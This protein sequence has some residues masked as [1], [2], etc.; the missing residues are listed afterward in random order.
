[1]FIPV[2]TDLG[3]VS[4]ECQTLMTGTLI[5]ECHV[6][7]DE[8]WY[9]PGVEIEVARHD[10][11]VLRTTATEDLDVNVTIRGQEFTWHI[12]ENSPLYYVT[13]FGQKNIKGEVLDALHYED[14]E[15]VP[16]VEGDPLTGEEVVIMNDFNH[17][18]VMVANI[19]TGAFKRLPVSENTTLVGSCILP[20]PFVTTMTEVSVVVVERVANSTVEV[21]YYDSELLEKSRV[22]V[23][24]GYLTYGSVS[25]HPLDAT[26]ILLM[27][28]HN[29]YLLRLVVSAD[30]S[31]AGG[32]YELGSGTIS[33]VGGVYSNNTLIEYSSPYHSR[34]SE[35]LDNTG[36]SFTFH[37]GQPSITP[38]FDGDAS[39]DQYIF[40]IDQSTS[41]LYRSLNSAS[42]SQPPFVLLKAV[43]SSVVVTSEQT[44]RIVVSYFD[45]P[46]ADVFNEELEKIGEL[47]LGRSAYATELNGKIVSTILYSD[48]PQISL[49]LDSEARVH[50]TEVQQ[51]INQPIVVTYN[52]SAPR[53]I[54]VRLLNDI[55]EVTV[56][57]VP[58]TGGLLPTSATVRFTVPAH[59][60]YWEHR[61]VGFTGSM[62]YV[63]NVRTEPQLFPTG[64]RPETVYD[65]S[66]RT[67]YTRT[68]IIEGLTEGFEAEL[69]SHSDQLDISVNGNEF[70]KTQTVKWRDEVTLNWEL[71]RFSDHNGRSENRVSSY[72]D[73]NA[74]LWDIIV[75]E[76]EGAAFIH[77]SSH[78]KSKLF[79]QAASESS[80]MAPVM[81]SQRTGQTSTDITTVHE[82]D[83]GV[84]LVQLHVGDQERNTQTPTQIAELTNHTAP[85]F[86][87]LEVEYGTMMMGTSFGLRVFHQLNHEV[88]T[89]VDY[90]EGTFTSELKTAITR[91]EVPYVYEPKTA[92]T[93]LEVP[94][95]YALEPAFTMLE[96]PYGYEPE[97]TTTRF[98]VSYVY[99]LK[100]AITP[101]E[102]P[103]VYE[104]ESAFTLREVEVGTSILPAL[105]PDKF[106]DIDVIVETTLGGRITVVTPDFYPRTGN[107]P[108]EVEYNSASS[109]QNTI[110]QY[111]LEAE[112]LGAFSLHMELV[113]VYI[114]TAAQFKL[115]VFDAP[116][117]TYMSYIEESLARS[118]LRQ[119]FAIKEY[120]DVQRMY[121]TWGVN[122]FQYQ[123]TDT[124]FRT[125]EFDAP[126]LYP[127]TAFFQILEFERETSAAQRSSEFEF[128]QET[129]AGHRSFEF[130]SER[131]TSAA[132]RSFE[133]GLERQYV[134]LPANVIDFE[135]ARLA[136]TTIAETS[137]ETKVGVAWKQ[138]TIEAAVEFVTSQYST[139]FVSEQ[140]GLFT[141]REAAEAYAATIDALP[142]W[143]EVV[144]QG[145]VWMVKVRPYDETRVCSAE[146]SQVPHQTYGYL[147][148][149]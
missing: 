105:S 133:F 26:T 111:H 107:D 65:A 61:Q 69:V 130:E 89:E 13:D 32:G 24:H 44:P 132:Q 101:F 38:V 21:V 40:T 109:R 12:R 53:A 146:E 144:S 78:I 108:H 30:G 104:L 62:T 139:G 56:N 115:E 93:G 74:I 100:P 103:Y 112:T 85:G 126:K 7:H 71:D 99:E 11:L 110:E 35:A 48:S 82:V 58:F 77:P 20:G 67:P 127:A 76:F 22:T 16:L 95:V 5:A 57:N 51:Q 136:R 129:S 94:Y 121:M 149:G 106:V 117:R 54:P 28:K 41:I 118:L 124:T 120:G 6:F 140:D 131:E 63:V 10:A 55:T 87:Y 70:A 122:E 116:D 37:H 145:E 97:P 25:V 134:A 147:G 113:A 81:Q 119:R 66:L 80:A 4:V 148:G 17:G 102:V 128:K 2:T 3:E 39:H 8:Q 96:V 9:E 83:V 137:V 92:I 42:S 135:T 68:V 34:V 43:P 49:S 45:H 125:L 72:Q 23:E 75:M 14:G 59:D 114:D 84:T 15:D 60:K 141:S 50:P 90:Y 86:D 73:R 29:R 52:H 142:E 47:E 33:G 64:V 143:I 27:P 19:V 138:D 91:L 18:S 31:F 1:M 123:F 79:H 46:V 36:V 98:E 88:D